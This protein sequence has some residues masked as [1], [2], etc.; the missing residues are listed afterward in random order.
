MYCK[1]C[2]FLK[3]TRYFLVM[4]IVVLIVAVNVPAVSAEEKQ[5]ENSGWEFQVAPYMWF[6]S[7]DGDVKVK[8]QKSDVDAS[9]SDIW[10]ELNIAA[11]VA[12]EGRKNRWGFFGDVIAANLGNSTTVGRIRIEPD[13]NALWLTAGGFYRLGTWD[14]SDASTNEEPT[15][16]LDVFAGARY[17]YLD[18]ELDFKNVPLPDPSGDKDWLDPLIGARAIFDLSEQWALSLDGSI[19]GFGVGS[20]FAWNAAGLIGYRFGFFGK[21]NATAFGGY[22]AMYQDYTEGSGNDQFEWDVTLHGPILGL[23]IRF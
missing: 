1:S 19:G 20:D 8:G 12:F 13:I 15:V 2:I 9:F 17:T 16:T 23:A 14:L 21:D 6:I 18:M 7:M 11:M 4:A 22:R 5:N 3:Q 10:D